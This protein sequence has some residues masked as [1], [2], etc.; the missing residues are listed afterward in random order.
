MHIY[1]YIYAHT[2]IHAYGYT[3]LCIY[4]YIYRQDSGQ[5]TYC[6][7]A[8]KWEFR[9]RMP[10]NIHWTFQWKPTGKVIIRWKIPP[11]N[12]IPLENDIRPQAS[13]LPLSVAMSVSKE[14]NLSTESNYQQPISKS[15]YKLSTE[16]N[17][18]P[19]LLIRVKLSTIWKTTSYRKFKSQTI[20][21]YTTTRYRKSKSQTTTS[22]QLKSRTTTSYRKHE[23]EQQWTNKSN[24]MNETWLIV[25]ETS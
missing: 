20:N 19:I 2:C 3:Y 11:N 21:N 8:Q 7:K 25:N 9:G 1:I 12:K 16:S 18:Q 24:E 14:A 4:I 6:Q 23:H 5:N 13:G 15:N 22:R 17:Y 10:L